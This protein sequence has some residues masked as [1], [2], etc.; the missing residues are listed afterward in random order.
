MDTPE[1]QALFESLR[2]RFS[3][4]IEARGAMEGARLAAFRPPYFLPSL[5]FCSHI[6]LFSSATYQGPNGDFVVISRADL[7]DPDEALAALEAK[8][9]AIAADTT[10]ALARPL[11]ESLGLARIEPSDALFEDELQSARRSAAV[12]L[13]EGRF[14]AAAAK[15]KEHYGLRLPR[16]MAVLAALFRSANALERA[17]LEYLGVSAGGLLEYFDDGGLD[18]VVREGLDPRVEMRFRRDPP[19]L[20][21]FLWG[22]T[23]GLHWG[24]FYDDP[25]E[26][27]GAIAHNYARDSG[28]T[29]ID[30][31]TS[32]VALL[33]ARLRERLEDPY[34]TEDRPLSAH[35]LRAAL[36]WFE[37]ADREAI[38]RDGIVRYRGVARPSM[39]GAASAVLPASA[40]NARLDPAKVEARYIEYKRGR[41]K[42]LSEWMMEAREELAKAKPAFAY[43]LGRELHWF[44]S[45]K[46]RKAGEEL[47]IAAYEALGRHAL[48]DIARAHY[49]HRDLPS[50]GVFEPG[51]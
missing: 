2:A 36:R 8:I 9:V 45:D 20:V 32:G 51:P 14:D 42:I 21:S 44:D 24:V 19:E 49:K 27:P 46:H 39:V 22:D 6:S 25:A 11:E 15:V 28:E 47:L 38:D 10:A 30:P 12:A 5:G 35:A 13:M 18:R 26:L 29:S 33:S 34:D 50:V 16:W 17:G 4:L 41:S 23:D 7:R 3:A 43:T 31:Q 37:A 40:G 48:A 1:M